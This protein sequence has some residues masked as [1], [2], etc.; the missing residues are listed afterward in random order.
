MASAFSEADGIDYTNPEE[1][2]HVK[3]IQSTSLNLLP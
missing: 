1:V 2:N 3:L